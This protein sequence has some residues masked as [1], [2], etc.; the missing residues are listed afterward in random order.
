MRAPMADGS[1]FEQLLREEKEKE[2]DRDREVYKI[3]GAVF[4]YGK[5]LGHSFSLWRG[6]ELRKRDRD[7]ST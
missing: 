5:K 4:K 6:R 3:S 7:A 1:C 2:M